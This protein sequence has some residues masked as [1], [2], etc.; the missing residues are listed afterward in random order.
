VVR[1]LNIDQYILINS[2]KIQ[3]REDHLHRRQDV[4]FDLGHPVLRQVPVDG[5]SEKMIHRLVITS[6]PFRWLL[7]KLTGRSERK[8]SII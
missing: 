7:L 2:I 4:P 6:E 3:Y 8:R 5:H 1:N